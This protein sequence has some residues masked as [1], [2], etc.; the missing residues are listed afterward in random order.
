[1]EKSTNTRHCNADF[2]NV[3]MEVLCWKIPKRVD[4]I[5]WHLVY[6]D[7]I[8]IAIRRKNGE[9]APLTRHEND[10]YFSLL[11][12]YSAV[13]FCVG[14]YGEWVLIRCIRRSSSLT[15]YLLCV[16]YIERHILVKK[17]D[18]NCFYFTPEYTLKRPKH[19]TLN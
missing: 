18:K 1:M 11:Y 6:E 17:S 19:R 4:G 12:M 5:L 2:T 10:S 16:S 9:K 15:Y 3:A 13:A 8:S 7:N 14:F